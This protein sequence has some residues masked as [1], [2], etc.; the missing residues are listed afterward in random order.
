MAKW[1]GHLWLKW[2]G[3]LWHKWVGQWILNFLLRTG[4]HLPCSQTSPIF[5]SHLRSQEYTRVKD[6]PSAPMYYCEQ[7]LTHVLCG[8][9]NTQYVCVE[10]ISPTL[11][12]N[13]VIQSFEHNN[14]FQK[15]NRRI[16]TGL[17]HLSHK[18]CIT[19]AT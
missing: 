16:Y 9:M 8:C 13:S 6:Q 7:E 3:H 5:A 15:Y 17:S 14:S 4:V 2:V 12:R 1:M 10:R 11:N 18:V 19:M